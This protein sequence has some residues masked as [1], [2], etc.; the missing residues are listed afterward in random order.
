MKLSEEKEKVAR[1]HVMS[2]KL[3]EAIK[4]VHPNLVACE[5]GGVID[6]YISHFKYK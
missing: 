3:K 5:Y 4:N 1:E 2:G 6:S